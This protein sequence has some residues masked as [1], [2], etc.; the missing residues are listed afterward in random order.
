MNKSHFHHDRCKRHNSAKHVTTRWIIVLQD[1][2][3]IIVYGDV[4][5]YDRISAKRGGKSFR[6]AG[7]YERCTNTIVCEDLCDF[8]DANQYLQMQSHNQTHKG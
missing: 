7:S 8:S 2:S 5:V 1:N 6:V 4:N 3:E